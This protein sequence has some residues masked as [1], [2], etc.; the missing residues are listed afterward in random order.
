MRRV[1]IT[2]GVAKNATVTFAASVSPGSL[3]KI[4]SHQS[5]CRPAPAWRSTPSHKDRGS[6]QTGRNIV[7]AFRGV[8]QRGQFCRSSDFCFMRVGSGFARFVLGLTF[9]L[10]GRQTE[11]RGEED[12]F[13]L[14]TGTGG[15]SICHR[16]QV[17]QSLVIQGRF[18]WNPC[19]L[20]Y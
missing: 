3:G 13:R 7:K 9:S 2:T 14:V 17:F 5:R 19:L 4:D 16:S 1:Q 8:Y 18:R 11:T 12:G 6:V 10:T 20:I 15:F